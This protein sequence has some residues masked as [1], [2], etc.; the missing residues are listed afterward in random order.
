MY[1][2]D[3]SIKQT[4]KHNI[5]NSTNVF[6]IPA[7]LNS[8]KNYE[9][10][11]YAENSK[12]TKQASYPLIKELKNCVKEKTILTK[13]NVKIDIWDIN[14][15]RCKKYIIFCEGISSEKSN[16]LQQKIYQKLTD[17]GWGVIAFDYRGKGKSSGYFSQNGARADMNAVF[18]YLILQGINPSDIGIIGHSLGSAVAVD[19]AIRHKT[20]FII[21][22]NPF[23]KAA[24][25]AKKIAQKAS[26]PD[27]VRKVIRNLPAFLI[28][29]KNNFDNAN[30]L[31]KI[32]SPVYII[33]T[34]DDP[35]IPVEHARKLASINNCKNIL[36]T[37][38]KGSDHELNDEKIDC[39]LKFIERYL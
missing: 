36:Y 2:V 34:K 23:F 12:L 15:F 33:H 25:M 13:D 28:P 19:F 11:F 10:N 32:K 9:K 1:T 35:V 39:C 24:D 26:M 38:L 30:A 22:I 18:N 3:Y 6:N 5:F 16:P 8:I 37:E 31:K 20:A 29:L 7:I 4:D 27:I 21:L 14:P 17:S